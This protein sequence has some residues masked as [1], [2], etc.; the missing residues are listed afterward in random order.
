MERI[1]DELPRGF[2]KPVEPIGEA[3]MK[4]FPKKVGI[5]FLE[6]SV[7]KRTFPYIKKSSKIR[8]GVNK[9]KMHLNFNQL[10][11]AHFLLQMNFVQSLFDFQIIA[12]NFTPTAIICIP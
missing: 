11:C 10:A 9:S 5:V 1:P 6:K 4:R 3:K 2:E 8:L 7:E 12:H